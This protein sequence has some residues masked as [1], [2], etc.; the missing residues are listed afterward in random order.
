MS[1]F[2]SHIFLFTSVPIKKKS[3]LSGVSFACLFGNTLT[4]LEI[5]GFEEVLRDF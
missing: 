5:S 4:Q 2:R 3:M 1:N